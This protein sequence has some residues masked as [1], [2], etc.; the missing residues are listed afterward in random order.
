MANTFVSLRRLQ[1]FY[2]GLKNKFALKSDVP[3][4]TSDLTNDSGYLTSAPVNS[5]NGQTGA[6]VIGS[7]TASSAG[8]MSATDKSNLDTLYADYLSASTALG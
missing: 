8:L 2:I 3:T 4:K 6:V 7:A 5:V 1:R